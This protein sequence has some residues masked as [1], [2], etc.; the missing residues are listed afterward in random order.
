M[1]VQVIFT[2]ALMAVALIAFAQLQQLPLIG[3]MSIC[4][5]LFGIYLVWMPDEATHI[6]RF[7]GVGRGADLIMYVWI[8]I[9]FAVWLLIYLSMR[10]QLQL[11]T[12]L[13]RNMALN[14]SF[15][16]PTAQANSN[17]Q[18]HTQRA[19]AL[20]PDEVDVR[21]ASNPAKQTSQ[22]TRAK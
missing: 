14:D 1:I 7:V 21:R 13:A 2:L 6:A 16:S 5:A 20:A 15:S 4:V 19:G 11:I 17:S 22:I 3:A 10:E 9:S 12:A 18:P 8:L